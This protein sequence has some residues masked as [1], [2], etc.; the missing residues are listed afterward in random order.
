MRACSTIAAVFML[1][2]AALVSVM[3]TGCVYDL[4]TSP[5]PCRRAVQA[6]RAALHCWPGISAGCCYSE[7]GPTGL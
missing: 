4:G 1:V 5:K 3:P 2:P 7:T 6:A